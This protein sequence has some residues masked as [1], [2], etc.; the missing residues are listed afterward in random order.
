MNPIFSKY[1][2]NVMRDWPVPTNTT[3]LCGFLGFTGYYRKFVANY[4][5]LAE[6]L[7][8]LLTKKEFHWDEC[9]QATF[10]LLKQAMVQT[11]VLALP[12]FK[13]PFA[14]KTEASDTGVGAVLIQDGHPVAYMSK[15]LG[16]KNQKLSDTSPSNK[17]SQNWM[18]HF[19]E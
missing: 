12:N 19:G 7:T 9:N 14:I 6:S 11:P 2:T 18:K 1:K 10:E 15:A 8:Q 5:I 17:S 4:G 16:V 13:R 3:E